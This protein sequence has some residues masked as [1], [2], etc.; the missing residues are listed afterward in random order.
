[1]GGSYGPPRGSIR[2]LIVHMTLRIRYKRS[3]VSKACLIAR[4]AA[5]TAL[6]T[7]QIRPRPHSAHG[8]FRNS[9]FEERRPLLQV[10]RDLQRNTEAGGLSYNFC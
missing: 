3:G 5:H 2:S 9:P 10:P 8:L 7:W 1:M 4:D 6:N